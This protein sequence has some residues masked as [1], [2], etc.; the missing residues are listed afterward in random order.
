MQEVSSIIMEE[1]V[2]ACLK[3]KRHTCCSGSGF[4]TQ[5]SPGEFSLADTMLPPISN[6]SRQCGGEIA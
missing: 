4:A 2:R 3:V 6:S 1:Y 5:P